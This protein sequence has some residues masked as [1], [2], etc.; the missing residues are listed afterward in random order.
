MIRNELPVRSMCSSGTN[1]I[2]CSQSISDLE[3][4]TCDQLHHEVAAKAPTFLYICRCMIG[5]KKLD[6][7]FPIVLAIRVCMYA[8]V[9]V[10]ICACIRVC[11]H[12][13]MYVCVNVHAC[14]YALCMCVHI[15]LNIIQDLVWY[16]KHNRIAMHS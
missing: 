2:L 1:S 3:H 13:C 16:E 12:V 6:W 7:W 8:C 5:F 4:F 15:V 10:A 11:M 14:L 9:H